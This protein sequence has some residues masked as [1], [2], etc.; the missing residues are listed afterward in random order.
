[1]SAAEQRA[2]DLLVRELGA[3]IVGT[4]QQVVL[5]KDEADHRPDKEAA[6]DD[7][8]ARQGGQQRDRCQ[9]CAR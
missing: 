9:R 3:T 1:V 7:A 4:A 2:V 6:A 8:G 5:D